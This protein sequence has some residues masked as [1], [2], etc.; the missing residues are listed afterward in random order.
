MESPLPPH[1]S[2]HATA[3]E[4]GPDD[5]KGVAVAGAE[6]EDSVAES[7]PSPSSGEYFDAL[8]TELERRILRQLSHQVR[9][10]CGVP[11]TPRTNA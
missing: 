1:L 7:T 4:V 3:P 5:S 2:R 6:A 10:R 9:R 11:L 8:D